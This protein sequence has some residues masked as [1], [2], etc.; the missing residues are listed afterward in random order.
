MNSIEYQTLE[1]LY[2]SGKIAKNYFQSRNLSIREKID[3]SS[4]TIADIEIDKFIKERLKKINKSW[5]IL[6]EEDSI[7]N[8]LKLISRENLFI[9]DPIDGT[10]S[11]IKGSKEFTINLSRLEKNKLVFSAI[12]IPME[13][14]I[15]FADSNNVY[16]AENLSSLNVTNNIKKI[17][18]IK[19]SRKNIINVITTKRESE[20]NDIRN[21]LKKSKK[22]FNFNSMASAKKFCSLASGL[23]D[24]YIRKAR[25]KIWDVIA[26]FHILHNVGYLIEDLDGNNL[27]K[28][29]S[30]REYLETISNKSFKICEF[31][32]KPVG[33]EI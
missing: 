4:V 10:S 13:D 21:F 16:I 23:N 6:S 11:F 33:L 31:I 2:E 14:I 7:E 1:I 17:D 20:K 32:I 8:Q 28:R 25:I 5:N 19:F 27:Y 24:I 29:I 15:Y 30:N 22:E 12:Y 26:G 9:I 3:D 18:R